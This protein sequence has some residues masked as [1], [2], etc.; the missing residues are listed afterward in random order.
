MPNQAA[1]YRSIIENPQGLGLQ[2][3]LALHPQLSRRTA[4]R[5]ISEMIQAGSITALGAARARKYHA[6]NN[7]KNMLRASEQNYLANSTSFPQHI[8][9]SA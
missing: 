4:Q 8:P 7:Q 3:L 6:A 5:I 2:E 1:I 9:V